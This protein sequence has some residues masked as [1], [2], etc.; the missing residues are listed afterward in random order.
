MKN[1][2]NKQ[3]NSETSEKSEKTKIKKLDQWQKKMHKPTMQVQC[4]LRNKPNT[5]VVWTQWNP[6]LHTNKSI[7][8]TKHKDKS[9]A[10]KDEP[11]RNIY[12]H[13]S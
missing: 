8:S 6:T 5:N 11:Q 2:I 3:T 13:K 7:T 10:Q 4:Q 12:K 1:N 9:K